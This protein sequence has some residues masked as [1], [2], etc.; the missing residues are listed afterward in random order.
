MRVDFTQPFMQLLEPEKVLR[1]GPDPAPGQDDERNPVTLKSIACNALM[2]MDPQAKMTGEEKV[3]RYDLATRVVKAESPETL[4][5][6][7]IVLL[8]K[9]IGDGFGPIIV[10]Q[11]FK[12]LEAGEA[13]E[14]KVAGGI[15]PAADAEVAE[16]T[17]EAA[18]K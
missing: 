9:V 2:A 18:D 6:E 7:D 16:I 3:K 17:K 13:N 14:D 1:D 8:K 5:A 10:G 15:S 11:A 4:E 12:M